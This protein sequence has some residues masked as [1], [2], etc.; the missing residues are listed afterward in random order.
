MAPSSSS[1]MGS[2]TRR[3]TTTSRSSSSSTPKTVLDKIIFAIRQ[4]PPTYKGVVDSRTAITKYLQT[5]LQYDNISAIKKA[6]KHG[7]KKGQ[8]IQIGQSFR[9]AGDDHIPVIELPKEE[10]VQITTLKM[11]GTGG[12][13]GNQKGKTTDEQDETSAVVDTVEA[14]EA[15]ASVSGCTTWRYG[16]GEISRQIR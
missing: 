9:V 7:V 4:H 16:C 12:G 14:A 2:T 1:I 3:G 6:L 11:K 8:L 10:R 15:V 5:E 13:G